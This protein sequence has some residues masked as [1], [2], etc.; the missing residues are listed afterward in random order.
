M[1][2]L[3]NLVIN[4]KNHKLEIEPNETLLDVIRNRV[5]LTG[6]KKGCDTGDCGACT[7]LLNGKAVNSCMI[8][9]ADV[10]GQEITT[11]EGLVGPNGELDPV[12]RA[13]VNNGAFQ[14]GYCTPGLIMAGRA[15][16]N[17]NPHPTEAE[18]R[19]GIGGNICRCTGY[20]TVVDAIMEAA[21]ANK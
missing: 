5:G 13:F 4:G 16:L 15:L 14:C 19:Q 6:T 17:E 9:A 3:V 8:L 18:I 21:E 1:K 12:Q 2:T 20:V 11:I 10:D 7:V